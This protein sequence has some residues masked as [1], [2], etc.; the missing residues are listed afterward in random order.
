VDPE[1]VL[2][3]LRPELVT[4]IGDVREAFSE[5][6]AV[7]PVEYRLAVEEARPK[8]M[9]LRILDRWRRRYGTSARNPMRLAEDEH[10]LRFLFI[11]G[12]EFSVGLRNK[13]LSG[14]GACYQHVSVRQTQLRQTNC[15][16]EFRM[17]VAHVFLGY[18]YTGG[19]NEVQPRLLDISLSAECVTPC[20]CYD[21]RWRRTVWDADDGIEPVRPIQ[22]PLFPP[23]APTIR[24]RRSAQGDEASGQQGG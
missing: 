17:H 19:P 23:P 14:S 18:R 4:L 5:F 16:P 8:A 3:L 22:A 20:G 13:R 10:R 15:F 24:P 1:A 21:V 9:H 11:E 6:D 12:D 7:L 2:A